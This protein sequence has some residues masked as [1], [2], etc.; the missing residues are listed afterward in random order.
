MRALYALE[1]LEPFLKFYFG[2]VFERIIYYQL[3]A[4]LS[5]HSSTNLG[6]TRF[7]QQNFTSLLEATD[8]WAYNIDIGNVNAVVFL[9]VDD[10]ILLSKLH[11][12][13]LIGVSYK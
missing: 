1:D 12:Y 11:L 2:K 13:G 5:D 9:T 6:S 4:Y 10:C 3:F 7:I 8:S